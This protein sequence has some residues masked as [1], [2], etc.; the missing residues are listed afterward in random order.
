M[1]S[2]SMLFGNYEIRIQAIGEVQIQLSFACSHRISWNGAKY[3]GYFCYG[4]R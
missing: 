1:R 3:F 4:R 2:T